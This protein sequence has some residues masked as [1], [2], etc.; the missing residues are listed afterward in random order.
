MRKPSSKWHAVTVVLRE[1]S[2]AAAALCR[3]QRFLAGQAPLLPLPKCA[4][5]DTCPCTYQHFD[6]RR[7][8]PRRA[9][10]SGAGL[11]SSKPSA[12]RRISRGRR[13]DDQR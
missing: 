2:C 8:G 9:V 11:D 1:S 5:P 12:N 10:E 13:T 7:R 4:H 6:D 3:N